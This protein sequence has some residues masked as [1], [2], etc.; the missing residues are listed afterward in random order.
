MM[1]RKVRMICIMR[2]K[3]RTELLLLRT[4]GI[5]QENSKEFSMAFTIGD[6]R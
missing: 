6:F 4:C 3:T 5:R 2:D 1:G